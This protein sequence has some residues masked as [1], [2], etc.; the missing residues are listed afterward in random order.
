MTGYVLAWLGELGLLYTCFIYEHE[1]FAKLG[2]SRRYVSYHAFELWGFVLFGVFGAIFWSGF[3]KQIAKARYWRALPWT[4]GTSVFVSAPFWVPLVFPTTVVTHALQQEAFCKSLFAILLNG[5]PLWMMY[6]NPF[7]SA[8]L[9]NQ[10]K[11]V[12]GTEVIPGGKAEKFLTK[13]LQAEVKKGDAPGIAFWGNSRLPFSKETQHLLIAGSPGSGKT[14]IIYPIMDQ[15]IARGDK[16]VIWDVKGDY[17][18][19]LLGRAGVQL[20]APWDARSIAWRPGADIINQMD[21][22][23]AAQVI[24]PANARDAQPFFQNA[25]RDLLRAALIQLDAAGDAWGCEDLWGIIGRGKDHLAQELQRT[26]EGRDKAHGLLEA[27]SGLDVYATLQTSAD[28]LRWLAKAWPKD[29]LSLRQWVKS[30]N[31]VA[32]VLILGGIPERDKLAGSTANLAIQVMVNQLLSMPDDR[33]RRVWFFLDELAALGRI[34]AISKLSTLGRSKGGCVVA[35]IQDIGKIEHLYSRELAKSMA[36]T[37]STM[38]FLRCADA[39]TSQWASDVIG[40]HEVLEYVSSQSQSSSSH[41]AG[42]GSSDSSSLQEQIRR[43]HAFLPSQIANFP[44]M[45]GLFR[46]SGWPVAHL[47]W[48]RTKIPQTA[49]VVEEAAWVNQKAKLDVI[50]PDSV[51]TDDSGQRK[52]LG[53]SHRPGTQSGPENPSG[54]ETQ[55]DPSPWNV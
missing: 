46:L 23:Q 17:T 33:N 19:A 31:P 9:A 11:V 44:D 55:H 4:L 29:G 47:A 40:E 32:Q 24:I 49:A 53:E 52:A 21:C 39:G 41:S 16:V 28:T 48:P 2:L 25:A 5:L 14:Q 18:Q 36:N 6:R 50:L 20:L 37:F 12:R 51:K 35:G 1:I 13:L 8:A 54:Q 22:D 42:S 15:A 34:E 45:E 27:K 3:L 43:K 38:I 10:G 7:G 26:E 30:P